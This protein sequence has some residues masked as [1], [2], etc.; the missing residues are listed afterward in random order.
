MVQPQLPRN[1]VTR[2]ADS[3]LSSHTG[4]RWADSPQKSKACFLAIAE[5]Q[6]G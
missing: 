4:R 6:L 1:G 3:F 5:I 2:G